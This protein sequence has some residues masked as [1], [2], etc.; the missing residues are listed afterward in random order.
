[1]GW[2]DWS[3]WNDVVDSPV[4]G[5]I[6]K[7]R[8]V[9]RTMV[10]DKGLGLRALRDL[11]E[12]GAPFIDYVK[13]A[14]GTSLLYRPEILLR[15][16][17]AVR[18]FDV[19]VYPGGTLFELAAARGSA[20]AFVRKVKDLGFTCI[21]VSDGTFDVP[22][23]ERRRRIE[24][25]IDAGLKVIAEVGKKEKGRRYVADEIARRVEI[26]LSC[27]ADMV[28]IEGR[29]SGVG[30]GVYEEDGSPIASVI[31]EALAMLSE[32]DRV[33]WE[34]PLVSQQQYW[35]KKLGVRANLGNVQAE[36]VLTLE[37]TR[38]ALR[39]DTLRD[40]ARKA[41]TIS[42]TEPS[43]EAEFRLEI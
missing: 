43:E 2:P 27:G 26:D 38:M 16:I 12:V 17:Y 37:A 10:I 24:L 9:G 31:D 7:P 41:S 3:A 19:D 32:P 14:F 36:D 28:V 20:E 8:R 34:A 30:V 21:E 39:G 6:A 35:L 42:D 40:F 33:M 1:M 25:G 4:S 22:L 11:L 15:K 18:Q 23:K 29:D 5:R 13:F